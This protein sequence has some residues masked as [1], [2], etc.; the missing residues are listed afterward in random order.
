MSTFRKTIAAKGGCL[1]ET[2]IRQ[3]LPLSVTEN[4]TR[5]DEYELAELA[6][7]LWEGDD[8]AAVVA[9]FDMKAGYLV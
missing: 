8:R 5:A 3:Y 4:L 1:T 9:A 7:E 2:Q 6:T